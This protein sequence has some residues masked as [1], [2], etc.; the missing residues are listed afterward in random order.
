MK[1]KK[2]LILRLVINFLCGGS[3][4]GGGQLLGRCKMAN[5][6]FFLILAKEHEE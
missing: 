3:G 1:K 5:Q 2:I 4:G 6:H